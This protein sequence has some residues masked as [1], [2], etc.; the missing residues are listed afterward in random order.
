GGS[1]DVSMLHA[2]ARVT[3][4]VGPG[5]RLLAA[6][7]AL[8]DA[9]VALQRVA[10]Q[11]DRLLLETQARVAEQLGLVDADEL[12]LRVSTA[13]RTIATESDEAWRSVRASLQ[14]PRGRTSPGRDLPLSP[15]LV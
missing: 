9:R 3:T 5:E 1:R 15:G 13:A 7:S 6:K 12:M 14:G 2:L 11:T 8:F 4:V 10:G